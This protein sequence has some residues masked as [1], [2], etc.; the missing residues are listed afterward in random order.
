VI[1]T[2]VGGIPELVQSG[3]HG[4]LIPGGDLSALVGAMESCLAASN[5]TI[6]EMGERARRRVLERHDIDKET[7]K[8]ATLFSA[9]ASYVSAEAS[10]VS[11][12]ASYACAEGHLAE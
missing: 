7:A 8:L 5:D 6:S 11:A 4:W 3:Q 10:Y 1:S 2:F 9:E 12:E